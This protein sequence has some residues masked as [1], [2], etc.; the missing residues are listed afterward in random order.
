[1]PGL[2]GVRKLRFAR[3]GQGKSGGFTQAHRTHHNIFSFQQRGYCD[4]RR[5]RTFRYPAQ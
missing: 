4:Q 3:K 5:E 2:G 1:M